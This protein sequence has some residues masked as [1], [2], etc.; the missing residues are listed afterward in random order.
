MNLYLHL[1]QE[2]V[3]SM[4]EVLGIFDMDTATVSKHTRVLLSRMEK[5]N[6]VIPIFDDLPKSFI[7]CKQNGQTV[8]YISQISTGTL[9]KRAE[10]QNLGIY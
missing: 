3:V 1:G 7:L 4:S 10:N 2:T 9:L 6:R 8:L 5:E